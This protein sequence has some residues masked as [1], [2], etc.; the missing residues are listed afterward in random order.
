[1]KKTY[2]LDSIK[3]ALHHSAS[4]L[5]DVLLSVSTFYINDHNHLQVDDFD[6][7]TDD[8]NNQGVPLIQQSLITLE[9]CTGTRMPRF[10]N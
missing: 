5:S 3:G 9:S 2:K 10:F 7:N 8:D 1:M 4:P 6:D